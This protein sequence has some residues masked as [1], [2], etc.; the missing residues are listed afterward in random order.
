MPRIKKNCSTCKHFDKK[1]DVCNDSG[2]P[3]DKY[4]RR[5]ECDWWTKKTKK[6]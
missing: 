4:V 5:V 1:I 6:R 2:Y 3:I